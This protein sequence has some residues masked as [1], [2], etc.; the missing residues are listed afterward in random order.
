MTVYKS[1]IFVL[2]KNVFYGIGGGFV[3]ALIG[4]AFMD[5]LYAIILG[6]VLGAAVIYITL[7]SDNIK[8][9]IDGDI[10]SFYRLGKLK[11]QFSISRVGLH[12]RIK[13]SGG[14]SDCT[15]TVTEPD[16]R[17]TAIDCSM[18]GERRFYKLL[19]ELKVGDEPIELA[20]TKKD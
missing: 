19:D 20:T 5:M 17:E 9:T 1:S 11:H 18:L 7:V 15:L 4:N 8:V 13:S 6:I 10:L 2:L 16:G 3:A 14:D 12:A